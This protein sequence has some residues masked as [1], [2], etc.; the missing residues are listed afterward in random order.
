MTWPP[1]PYD[2]MLAKIEEHDA[3]YVGDPAKL[4][5][6]Y[7]DSKASHKT[8][9]SQLSGGLVG[10]VARFF[11]GRPTPAGQQRTRIHIPLGSDIATTSA[12]LLFSEPP[13]ILLPKLDA[14][15]TQ[16]HPAQKRLEEIVGDPSFAA[17]L[18]EGA[19]VQSAHGGVYLRIVWDKDLLDKPFL[20]VVAADGAIPK[21][22]F[23]RL[24]SVM[25]WTIIHTDGQKIVR[26]VETHGK[27][28]IQHQVFE[29]TASELGNPVPLTEYSA[30]SWAAVLVNEESRIPTGTERLTAAYVPNMLPQRTWRKILELAPL[31]RSDFDGVEALFD[32]IDEVWSSWMRDIRLAKARVFVDQNFLTTGGPGSGASF[33]DDQELFT[34]MPPGAGSMESDKPIDVAQFA[35]RVAEHQQTIQELTRAALRAAG[36]SPASLGDDSVS[37]QETATQVKSK[38]RLSDRT[39]DKKIR[40]W[41]SALTPLIQAMLDVDA[42]VFGPNK[43]DGKA[44]PEVRFTEKAQQDVLELAETVAMLNSAEAI[45]TELKV[46]MVHPDW[47][48]DKVDEEV[49]RIR[50]ER[51]TVPE[52]FTERGL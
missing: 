50:S 24:Q 7:Q 14:D 26:H 36:F 5:Q 18:V 39:R 46:R 10:K 17:T 28:W 15:G 32:A 13:R 22:L 29:G 38:E 35:I 34:A 40:Y 33:D 16:D 47:D 51:S 27:G 31:G 25:F 1:K 2:T 44:R 4:A 19:E 8:R 37:V 20:T 49:E 6:I 21:F 45:S 23:G 12:D 41:K 43:Y 3:W 11:W 9:P 42:A 30:T 48:K 52:P